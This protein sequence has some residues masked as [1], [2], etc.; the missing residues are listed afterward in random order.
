[1]IEESKDAF[2]K[3]L[4]DCYEG[5]GGPL[6]TERDDGFFEILTTDQYFDEF[7]KWIE[8]HKEA[9][10]YVEGKVLDVGCGAG[11]HSLYLQNNGFDVVGIDNSPLVI[12]LCK[13]RGV[14]KSELQDLHDLSE[15]IGM[16]DTIIMLGNNFTLVGNPIAAKNILSKFHLITSENGR[17]VAECLDPYQTEVQ[18]H[19]EYHENNKRRG[20]YPGHITLRFHYKKIS[21]SWIDLLLLSKE[22]MKEIVKGTGWKITNFIENSETPHYLAIFEK[23]KM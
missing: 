4:L 9:M 1:M 8:Y 13:L 21:S 3:A 22:E 7:D 6:I 2:G 23:E 11:R 16:F 17:I 5:K 12:K 14:K 20:R 18:D 15:D 19:L 10:Y